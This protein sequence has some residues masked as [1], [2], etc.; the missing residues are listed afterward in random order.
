M[1]NSEKYARRPRQDF[2]KRSVARGGEITFS[3]GGR[4]I[5][6]HEDKRKRGNQVSTELAQNL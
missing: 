5:S 4:K 2:K 6:K 3:E 1:R